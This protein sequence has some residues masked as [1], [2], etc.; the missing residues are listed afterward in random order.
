L[1]QNED[2]EPIYTFAVKAEDNGKDVRHS[3]TIDV[4]LTVRRV[5]EYN[6]VIITTGTSIVVD[7]NIKVGTVLYKVL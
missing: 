3:S 7:E 6:P 4:I 5:N 1:D 2:E